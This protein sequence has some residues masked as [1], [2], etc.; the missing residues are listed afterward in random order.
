LPRSAVESQGAN[1]QADATGTLAVRRGD[2][3]PGI[4]T[5]ALEFGVSMD[6]TPAWTVGLTGRAASRRQAPFSP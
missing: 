2:Q 6:I 4:P 3:L 5:H 1:S